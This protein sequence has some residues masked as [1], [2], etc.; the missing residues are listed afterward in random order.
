[1]KLSNY[2]LP[3][4]KEKPSDAVLP[5]HSL[6]IR[7][8]LIRKISGG[9]YAYLPFGLKTL[10]K[11]ESIIRE[12]MNSSG[13]Q[14]FLFPLLISR[15][16]WENSGRWHTFK[17]ELFR[18]KDR[19]DN[20]YALGPTHEETFTAFFKREVSSYKDLPLLLYQIAPKFRDEIRPRY[21]VM[22]GKEFF[23]KD[24]YSFH[25][26]DA[27][28][29]RTYQVMRETYQKIFKRLKLDFTS[30]KADS[31]TMGGDRSEEFMV[32]SD[33]GEETIILC[34]LCNYSTN[35]ETAEEK[36]VYS[37]FSL[38][39][40]Y[41]KREHAEIKYIHTPGKTKISPVAKYLN[42]PES[43]LIKC[44][45]YEVNKGENKRIIMVL[46]RGDYEVN[47]T[48]LQNLFP[49]GIKSLSEEK[50]KNEGYIRGYI[51]FT[52]KKEDGF[53]YID[54]SLNE[55][56]RFIMGANLENF[57]QLVENFQDLKKELSMR[58]CS[59]YQ[60]KHMGQCKQCGAELKS[61][62][63]I[64]IGHI[65]KLGKKYTE[66][67]D[68]TVLDK[69]GKSQLPTMGC[70]GIG[71]DRTL[72]AIIEQNHDQDGIRWPKSVSPFNVHL[73]TVN[74]KDELSFNFSQQVYE[75][76]LNEGLDT[77][78]DD[79]EQHAGFKF[80]EAD[81]MGLP[82]QVI[83]GPKRLTEGKVEIKIRSTGEKL[84]VISDEVI[85]FIIKIHNK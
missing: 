47:P 19:A 3:S 18:L 1:M 44:L 32:K 20:D 5:S 73:I 74:T 23:M 21:G 15:S 65:F 58:Q 48:K 24:A 71:L 13:G 78:W 60:A 16:L 68:A 46:I 82:L 40:E 25:L 38:N 14:E 9:F 6:M 85:D 55:G 56:N 64:E 30:V 52:K 7:A 53:Y 41:E 50:M 31:G 61:S 33:V 59:V 57:H 34:S 26:N 4:L 83:V 63:G 80:K 35:L 69:N 28:L 36:I 79:R 39:V 37:E 8:G 45:L 72:A 42:V 76:L 2:F 67:F 54:E 43:V 10:R 22:R 75:N 62:K 11:I 77:L 66:S 49:E 81:L 51:G 29:D 27:C 12:E 84:E 17:K 70:Y